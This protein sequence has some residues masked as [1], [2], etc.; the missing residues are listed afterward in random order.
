MQPPSASTPSSK[1]PAAAIQKVETD[2]LKLIRALSDLKVEADGGHNGD[3]TQ[4]LRRIAELTGLSKDEVNRY[5]SP[6][7]RETYSYD[8]LVHV[9]GR[10]R[11]LY[12]WLIVSGPPKVDEGKWAGIQCNTSKHAIFRAVALRFGYEVKYVGRPGQIVDIVFRGIQAVSSERVGKFFST[13][14]PILEIDRY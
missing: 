8:R 14:E 11:P 7:V 2:C 6:T 1:G 12:N 13:Q 9:R 5:L 4:S 10:N 3:G